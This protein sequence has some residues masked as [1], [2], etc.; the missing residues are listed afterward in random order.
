GM[1][2]APRGAAA[3]EAAATPAKATPTESAAAEAAATP[4]AREDDRRCAGSIGMRSHATERADR[5][6]HQQQ[7]EEHQSRGQGGQQRDT[8]LPRE[9]AAPRPADQRP[10]QGPEHARQDEA[11]EG[12]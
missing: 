10:R 8:R 1:S 4:A 9:E 11:D 5:T 6:E 3:A 7:E 12:D 2:P